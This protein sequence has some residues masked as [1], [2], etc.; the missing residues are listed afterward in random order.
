MKNFTKHFWNFHPKVYLES[1]EMEIFIRVTH[2]GTVPGSILLADLDTG[3]EQQNRKVQVYVPFGGT[4]N[5]PATSRSI[6]SYESGNIRKFV[7]DGKLVANMFSQPDQV[8]NLSR[9]PASEYPAGTS[10]WNSDDAAPN[11]SDG[12]DWRDAA[13]NLT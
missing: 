8:T 9:P 1:T 10:V 11:F 5:I 4:V 12:T 7:N 6:F 2:A 13:G 3:L